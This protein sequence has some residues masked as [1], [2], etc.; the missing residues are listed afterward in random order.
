[1]NLP[2]EYSSG[3]W[4]YWLGIDAE[5]GRPYVVMPWSLDNFDY[6]GFYELSNDQYEHLVADPMAALV[7]VGECQRHEHDD[8]LRFSWRRHSG[9][10]QGGSGGV[11]T[12]DAERS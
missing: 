4:S 5:T 8:L 10:A 3:Q 12:P 7:F 9:S 11:E 2:L 1:M 6:D